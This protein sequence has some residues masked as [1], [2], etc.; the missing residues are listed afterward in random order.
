MAH[1]RV[2]RQVY[3]EAQGRVFAQNEFMGYPIPLTAL[4]KRMTSRQANITKKVTVSVLVPFHTLEDNKTVT[5]LSEEVIEILRTLCG[6]SGLQKVSV[7][8]DEKHDNHGEAHGYFW[9]RVMEMFE[10]YE[11]DE[12]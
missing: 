9:T 7:E 6:M 10:G 12:V 5:G 4:F 3:L 8:W 2:S 11:R 1:S